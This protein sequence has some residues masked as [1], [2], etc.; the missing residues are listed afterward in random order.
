MPFIIGEGIPRKF[1]TTTYQE[2][3]TVTIKYQKWKKQDASLKSWLLSSMST[4]FTTQMVGFEFSYQIWQKLETF[5]SSQVKEKVRQLK[6]ILSNTKKEGSMNAYQLDIKKVV[7]TLISIGAPLSDSDHVKAI[8]GGLS[9]EY[10]PFITSIN[11]REN[12]I[13]VGALEALLMA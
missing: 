3:G 13:S 2:N 6:N 4:S 7:D 1:G 11:S 10:G 12:P 8:L 9:E 5:F